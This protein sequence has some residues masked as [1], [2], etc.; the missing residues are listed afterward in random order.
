MYV[1]TYTTIT[2]LKVYPNSSHKLCQ[3]RVLLFYS[4]WVEPQVQIPERLISV[5]SFPIGVTSLM[6]LG[7][8]PREEGQ[9]QDLSL[10]EHDLIIFG[11]YILGFAPLDT[12]WKSYC[13]ICYAVFLAQITE[14]SS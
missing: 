3:A 6:S 9:Y 14:W 4:P 13:R 2:H 1:D 10:D 12:Y 5:T 7:L 8:I 11:A